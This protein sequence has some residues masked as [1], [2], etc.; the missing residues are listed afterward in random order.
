MS[1][2]AWDVT[3]GP[4]VYMAAEAVAYVGLLLL[5]ETRAAR[6]CF[7]QLNR[8]RVAPFLLRLGARQGKLR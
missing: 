3:G 6:T 4:L 5:F 8:L 1:L 7:Q 2:F